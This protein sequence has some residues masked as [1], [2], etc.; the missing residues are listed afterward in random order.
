M[1]K[2]RAVLGQF[3]L[4]KAYTYLRFATILQ[5]ILAVHMCV[6]RH[7]NTCSGDFW[8]KKGW[9]VDRVTFSRLSLY[10]VFFSFLRCLAAQP[11]C[12]QPTGPIFLDFVFFVPLDKPTTFFRVRLDHDPEFLGQ[13]YSDHFPLTDRPGKGTPS[14]PISEPKNNNVVRPKQNTDSLKT[15][16]KKK[17]LVFFGLVLAKK[18][19]SFGWGGGGFSGA[20]ACPNANLS[21]A[22]TLCSVQRTFVKPKVGLLSIFVGQSLYLFEVRHNPAKDFSRAHVC[23]ASP[24]HVFGWFLNK[25]EWKVDRVTFSRLSL[26]LSFFHSFV[27]LL[28]SSRPVVNP[29][30][31]FCHWTL[32]FLFP[33][34]NHPLF[35]GVEF[36]SM[37]P[38]FEVKVTRDHFILITER[39]EEEGKS[40]VC[41]DC[42]STKNQ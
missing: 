35:S 31:P 12:S 10:F 29:T 38:N 26:I 18:T 36:G 33:R 30:G 34:T 3:L 23:S 11:T 40:G 28:H 39:R 1:H 7:L 19:S 25:K 9:K 14:D 2:G 17:V 20:S 22:I 5:R 42:R 37:T 21:W 13:I 24:E 16:R 32:S 8:N 27:V 41:S 6:L 15:K 4:G